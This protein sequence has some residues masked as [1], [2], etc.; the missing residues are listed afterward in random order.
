VTLNDVAEDAGV[1]LRTVLRHFGSRDGLFEAAFSVMVEEISGHCAPT[2]PGDIEAAIESLVNHYEQDGDLNLKTLEEESDIPLLHT[3]LEQGRRI[4][5][6]WLEEIFGPLLVKLSKAQFQAK[7][8]QLYAATDVYL[9]KL[10]RRDLGH[11]RD[12]TRATFEQLVR[13]CLSISNKGEKK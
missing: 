7:M 2:P 4:H 8:I 1:A 3:L 9:W 10:L 6:A 11:S 13:G 5:R 12:V